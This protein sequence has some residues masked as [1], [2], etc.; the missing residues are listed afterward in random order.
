MPL[1]SQDS[2]LFRSF[3]RLTCKDKNLLP[4]KQQKEV[5][6]NHQTTAELRNP[7]GDSSKS[8]SSA[9]G[10]RSGSAAALKYAFVNRLPAHNIIGAGFGSGGFQHRKQTGRCLP[11]PVKSSV[12]HII[13]IADFESYAALSVIA[14]SPAFR[15]SSRMACSIL[16]RESRAVSAGIRTSQFHFSE[17]ENVCFVRNFLY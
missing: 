7:T 14:L 6:L 15:S 3:L 10:F 5:L 4:P 16:R 17:K 9:P 13:S 12:D 8:S 1:S 2:R 11:L